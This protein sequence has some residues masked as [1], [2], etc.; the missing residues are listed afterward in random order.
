MKY[1]FIH[2]YINNNNFSHNMYIIIHKINQAFFFFPFPFPFFFG[3]LFF[4]K[5]F[6]FSKTTWDILS[7]NSTLYKFLFYSMHSITLWPSINYYYKN[8]CLT[9]LV[10]FKIIMYKWCIFFHNIHYRFYNSTR[11]TYIWI[12]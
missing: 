12:H 6:I 3:F 7:L 5:F 9:Y 8:T 2:I 4:V 10:K 1:I 11:V